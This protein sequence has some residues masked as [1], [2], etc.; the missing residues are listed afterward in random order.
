LVGPP[1]SR[2]LLTM[3]SL[4]EHR[5]VI[6]GLPLAIGSLCGDRHQ[7]M[8]PT[9]PCDGARLM[10]DGN[11]PLD[12]NVLNS[13]TLQAGWVS[14]FVQRSGAAGELKYYILDN[15]Y[16]IWRS[17]RSDRARAI[18]EAAAVALELRFV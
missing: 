12:A 2:Q 4:V 3:S 13:T 8:K 16:S 7:G 15:E 11:N 6:D 10:R 18:V 14:H 5:H 1:F 9:P 17:H